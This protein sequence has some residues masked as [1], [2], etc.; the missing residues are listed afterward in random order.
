MGDRKSFCV[1]FSLLMIISVFSASSFFV[2][3]ADA[4]TSASSSGTLFTPPT[5]EGS[6][7]SED[8]FGG[9]TDIMLL[10]MTTGMLGNGKYSQLALLLPL[11]GANENMKKFLV[12]LGLAMLLTSSGKAKTPAEI[13]AAT[14]AP[15]VRTS[16]DK[17]EITIQA[18]KPEAGQTEQESIMGGSY[19]V[20]Q[21][22]ESINIDSLSDEAGQKVS[23]DACPKFKSQ[24]EK[25][26]SDKK[27]TFL[28]KTKEASGS[29]AE[30]CEIFY[31]FEGGDT[32]TVSNTIVKYKTEEEA[33]I[34]FKDI[35]GIGTA[36]EKISSSMTEEDVN[37]LADQNSFIKFEG[38]T[39]EEIINEKTTDVP[40]LRISAARIL[41]TKDKNIIQIMFGKES[42]ITLENGASLEYILNINERYLEYIKIKRNSPI[43][44]STANVIIATSL[45]NK[46]TDGLS[47][48]IIYADNKGTEFIYSELKEA[49]V[50]Y[51]VISAEQA[52]TTIGKHEFYSDYLVGCTAGA[53]HKQAGYLVRLDENGNVAEALLE[54]GA[55]YAGPD[56]VKIKFWK[57]D[58]AKKVN[59][60]VLIYFTKARPGVSYDFRIENKNNLI[61]LRSK[62]EINEKLGFT[63][64]CGLKG[65]QTVIALSDA[66]VF[67]VTYAISLSA[68]QQKKESLGKVHVLEGYV[69]EKRDNNKVIILGKR[70]A[71]IADS[72]KQKQEAQQAIRELEVERKGTSTAQPA[73][74]VA[75][76]EE[77]PIPSGIGSDGGKRPAG[78]PSTAKKVQGQTT[79]TPPVGEPDRSTPDIR[80]LLAARQEAAGQRQQATQQMPG[81]SG[82]YLFY[83]LGH[84]YSFNTP[85]QTIYLTD[86]K[87]NQRYTASATEEG[88][89]WSVKLYSAL[90]A[91]A[92]T[93]GQVNELLIEVCIANTPVELLNNARCGDPQKLNL[94]R[95]IDFASKGLLLEDPK[96]ETRPQKT[97]QESAGKFRTIGI[98]ITKEGGLASS[99]LLSSTIKLNVDG[100]KISQETPSQ[101]FVIGKTGY[102]MRFTS[103]FDQASNGPYFWVRLMK[104]GHT[105]KCDESYGRDEIALKALAGGQCEVYQIEQTQKID[106]ECKNVKFKNCYQN[107]KILSAEAY[108]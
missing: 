17:R 64:N 83:G 70:L 43:S 95:P 60:D 16:P 58:T 59:K 39:E 34:I 78:G 91:L 92:M 61:M 80:E 93:E 51:S 101:L 89:Y 2:I 106:E 27:G 102:A 1:A 20:Y 71:N 76:P 46:A 50:F 35:A 108:I 25:I 62:G 105:L 53:G 73:G 86:K 66:D 4:T 84:R 72:S 22:I 88:N 3:A 100:S 28:I 63:Y 11:V 99:T 52:L 42:K 7:D 104:D 77:G 14:T 85:E 49:D 40:K 81:I 48:N 75:K 12:P 97:S 94:I 30:N 56:K 21:N 79:V 98:F 69:K 29:P 47:S 19:R 26:T 82:K 74:L 31:F 32:L 33:N 57:T 90:N 18:A 45:E 15:G 68:S 96:D 5:S 41:S 87:G 103:Y 55:Q 44:I 24:I 23:V 38:F 37:S 67:E 8:G 13:E 36:I 54:S 107:S 6:S 65:E 9:M 10:L